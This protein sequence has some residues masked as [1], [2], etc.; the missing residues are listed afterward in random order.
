M[1]RTTRLAAALAAVVTVAAVAAAGP[2][3]SAPTGATTAGPQGDAVVDP[4]A[5]A[6]A[7][8]PRI[9]A[10]PDRSLVNTETGE[11]FRPRGFNYVRLAP[12]PSKPAAPYHSTFEPGV[13]DGAR[14]DRMLAD[15]TTK[16]YD[17]VRVFVDPGNGQDNHIGRPH[18]LG[19]GDADLSPANPTYLD[20]LADFVRRAASYGM[21]VLPSLDVFPQ[22]GYYRDIIVNSPQPV[23]M[24]GR[25][26]TYMYEGYIRAKEEYLRVFTREMR[27]RLGD[28]MSTF[29]ALQ[30]DNEAYLTYNEAPFHQFSGTVTVAGRAYSMAD[31]AQ[32]QAAAD[33]AFVAYAD[34]GVAAVKSVDPD[35]MV[36][37]GAFTNLAVG[38]TFD[39]LSGVCG[40]APCADKRYPVRVSA[41]TRE[42]ALD[43]LDI[44]LYLMTGRTLQQSLS[45]MEWSQVTGPVVNGEFGTERKWFGNDILRAK[46]ALV[47]H[48][49]AT[50]SHGISGW[51]Y[52]TW[53]TDE[54]TTQRLFFTGTEGGGV[55][56]SA[57]SP[58]FRANPCGVNQLR[59]P[60][61]VVFP[62]SADERMQAR[63]EFRGYQGDDVVTLTVDG[64]VV[65][66]SDGGSWPWRLVPTRDLPLGEPFDAE[67]R[68]YRDGRLFDIVIKQDIVLGP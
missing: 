64:E 4:L 35:L 56:G 18:G 54:D 20:N 16:G 32:R 43:F 63:P 5:D 28:L 52:W 42:S 10:G 1:K 62:L 50:C 19:H 45:S 48:Q 21:Y 57:L 23:N 67:F 55:I 13:Y 27:D 24:E 38:K 36:T 47:D 15:L 60:A 44:H 65:G 39:G 3:S 66:R 7:P 41:L 59:V 49:V 9:A 68:R 61:L 6:V 25:N 51:L 37:M 12:M 46:T 17:T 34:R 14:A 30:L 2:A 58:R 22:N 26:R 8:L 11:Q 40:G 31:K 29:L 33:A 53:D